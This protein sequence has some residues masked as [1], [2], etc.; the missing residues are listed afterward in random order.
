MKRITIHWRGLCLK[1]IELLQQWWQQ[2]SIF[3]LKTVFP[4]KQFDE[5][6]TDPTP[7]VKLHLLN[8][9]LLKTVLKGKKDGVMIIRPGCLMTGNTYYG[10]M[11]CS[12]HCSQHQA[13]FMPREFPRKPIILNAWFQLWNMEAEP[14][15]FGQHQYSAGPI[16]TLNG[17]ITASEYVDILGTQVHPMVLMLFPINDAIFQDDI[18]PIYSQKFSVLL[19]KHEDALRHL[20][21][22][23]QSPDLN[24]IK[25]L[26]SGLQSRVRSG[27]PLPPSL[28]QLD[29][30]LHEEWYNI[31]PYESIPWTWAVL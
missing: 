27:F 13:R 6:F 7:T 24:I 1:I 19:E 25:P 5:I 21:W 12:S 16:I 2:N 18:L 8:H 15:R 23:A 4:Q 9:W 3:I 28:K 11:S 14:W 17:H 31:P 30:V 29:H 20:P 22:P 10:Q 26:W